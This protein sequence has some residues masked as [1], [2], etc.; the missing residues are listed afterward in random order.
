[1]LNKDS[2]DSSIQSLS[3]DKLNHN[4]DDTVREIQRLVIA[5]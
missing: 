3:V 5:K 4:D 1:M 2:L